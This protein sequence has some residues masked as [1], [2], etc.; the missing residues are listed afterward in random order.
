MAVSG[1]SPETAR[2]KLRLRAIGTREDS[3]QSPIVAANLP[4]GWFLIV[5]NRAAHRL[6]T[7]AVLQSL[8]AGCEVSM[9]RL[10][11]PFVAIRDRYMAQQRAEGAEAAV[12]YIFEVPV[13]LIMHFTGYRHDQNIPDFGAQ[14]FEVLESTVPEKKA[15]LKWLFP[16]NKASE[17]SGLIAPDGAQNKRG[18]GLA[19]D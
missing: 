15:W 9:A 4:K 12:D 13:E 5:A 14:P 19:G 2:D 10:P 18:S 3:A 11:T 6:L 17:P 16:H 8:S 1:K 7:E